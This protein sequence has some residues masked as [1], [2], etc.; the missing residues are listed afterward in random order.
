[1]IQEQNAELKLFWKENFFLIPSATSLL[2]SSHSLFIIKVILSNAII[3]SLSM[4]N[5]NHLTEWWVHSFRCEDCPLKSRRRHVREEVS[6]K[7]NTASTE[8]LIPPFGENSFGSGIKPK[9]C[10]FNAFQGHIPSSHIQ[11]HLPCLTVEYYDRNLWQRKQLE[12]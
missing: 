7:S 9:P 6:V 3:I 5:I 10:F 2:I 4:S 1:M 8:N 11:M 12:H